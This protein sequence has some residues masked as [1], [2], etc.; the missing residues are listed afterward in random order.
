M[1]RR[2]A[3]PKMKHKLHRGDA[4][5]SEILSGARDRYSREELQGLDTTNLE[6]LRIGKLGPLQ[7]NYCIAG[8][9]D[10]SLRSGLRKR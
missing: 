7:S 9:R 5:F 6:A 4:E 10:P 2:G 1:I 3:R 8:N